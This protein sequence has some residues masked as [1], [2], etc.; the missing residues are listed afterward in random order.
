MEDVY[1]ATDNDLYQVRIGYF[2]QHCVERK[3]DLEKLAGLGGHPKPSTFNGSN[4]T[5]CWYG[6]TVRGF[7]AALE[8]RDAA[9]IEGFQ[10]HVREI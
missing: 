1:V 2:G 7:A 8:I 6:F 9:K 4:Q 5:L 10:V 3:R